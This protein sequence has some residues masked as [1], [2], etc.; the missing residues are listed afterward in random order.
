MAA[1]NGHGGKRP[2]SG[3]KSKAE[4]LGLQALLDKCWTQADREECLQA[5]ARTA[6]DPLANNRMDAIKLL[7]SYTYGTPKATV[8]LNHGGSITTKYEVEIGGGRELAEPA[9]EFVN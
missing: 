5:L 1:G 2:N 3:R 6:N 9:T 7:M 8:D 4:E